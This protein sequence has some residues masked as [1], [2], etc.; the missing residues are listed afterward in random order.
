MTH[1]PPKMMQSVPRRQFFFLTIFP[2]NVMNSEFA[3]LLENVCKNPFDIENLSCRC[4]VFSYIACGRTHILHVEPY[5][6]DGR[7][8][9]TRQARKWFRTH[10]RVQCLLLIRFVRIL[11]G[12]FSKSSVPFWSTFALRRKICFLYGFCQ[13][14][15][16][17]SAF[18][19]KDAIV[20]LDSALSL[21]LAGLVRIQI[22]LAGRQAGPAKA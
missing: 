8:S 17:G 6:S 11:L 2:K 10:F 13:S 9:T 1:F 5:L 19:K 21:L 20:L 7:L 15:S 4:I 14:L 12:T 22:S 3:A 18:A 16:H